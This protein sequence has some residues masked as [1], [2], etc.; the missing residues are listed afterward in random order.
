MRKVTIPKG[1]ISI[2]TFPVYK[3]GITYRTCCDDYSVSISIE[4]P[5]ELSLYLERATEASVAPYGTER[6]IY[7][8]CVVD[9]KVHEGLSHHKA[10]LLIPT[11][12]DRES[13]LFVPGLLVPDLKLNYVIKREGKSIGS[14]LTSDYVG[15][16]E[17]FAPT[18]LNIDNPPDTK[19]QGLV[20]DTPQEKRKRPVVNII[21]SSEGNE[22][23]F[24]E[25]SKKLEEIMK[26]NL[27]L[28]WK[29]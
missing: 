26:S 16:Q 29:V 19:Y 18:I 25:N 12:I 5:L 9:R 27:K 7:T 20:I 1:T 11:K 28:W 3:Q 13:K 23:I 15:D 24:Q 8:P 6:N 22:N 14:V 10:W 17:F 2:H 4:P 21:L